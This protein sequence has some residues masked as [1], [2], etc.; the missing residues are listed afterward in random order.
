MLKIQNLTKSFGEKI[1]VND[2]SLNV[3]KGDI[4]VF[5]KDKIK[6]ICTKNSYAQRWCEANQ[7][8]YELI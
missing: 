8:K 4:I 7:R 2:V 5:T 6:I 1:A 3:E